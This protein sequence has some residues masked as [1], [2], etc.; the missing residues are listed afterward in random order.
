MAA[1]QYGDRPVWVAHQRSQSGQMRKF[2]AE[3]APP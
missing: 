1:F 3:I 2:V